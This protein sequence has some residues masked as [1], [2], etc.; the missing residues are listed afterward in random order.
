[1]LPLK[2]GEGFLEPMKDPKEEN[3]RVYFDR[4]AGG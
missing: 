3:G 4:P 2:T 1:M